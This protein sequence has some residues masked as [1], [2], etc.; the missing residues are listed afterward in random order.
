MYKLLKSCHH[1]IISFL[2]VPRLSPD[3]STGD[4]VAQYLRT[5]VNTLLENTTIDH[6][7]RLVDDTDTDI[8]IDIDMDLNDLNDNS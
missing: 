7:E 2:A 5:T 6:S 4:L 3:S 1:F 8:E